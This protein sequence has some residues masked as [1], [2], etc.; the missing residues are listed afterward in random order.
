[1][2]IPLGREQAVIEA[3]IHLQAS[4]PD[5]ITNEMIAEHTGYSRATVKRVISAL[6]CWQVIDREQVTTP[7]IP[8]YRY[9]YE[10]FSHV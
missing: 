8:G 7:G 1:M 4:R 3:I 5:P 9:R 10:V 6:L 2:K